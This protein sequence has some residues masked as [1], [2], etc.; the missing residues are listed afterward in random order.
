MELRYPED[1][2]PIPLK[3]Q[4]RW[5]P[6]LC[7]WIWPKGKPYQDSTQEEIE[8]WAKSMVN[9]EKNL[10]LDIKFLVC[11]TTIIEKLLQKQVVIWRNL[12]GKQKKT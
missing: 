7:Y 6:H 1:F 12:L 4:D 2:R 3:E 9:G 8:A 10:S 5:K 11:R